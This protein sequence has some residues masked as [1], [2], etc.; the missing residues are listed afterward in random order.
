MGIP[1]TRAARLAGNPLEA[2]V[3]AGA[4]A[5]EDACDAGVA[6]LWAAAGVDGADGDVL[7][8]EVGV[9]EAQ[10]AKASAAADALMM[11][12]HTELGLLKNFITLYFNGSCLPAKNFSQKCKGAK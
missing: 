6:A 11:R 10:L 3:A 8:C 2:A 1:F 7:I 5:L 9:G 4:A 12:A